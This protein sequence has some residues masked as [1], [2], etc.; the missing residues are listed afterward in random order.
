MAC[1]FSSSEFGSNGQ[2]KEI[3]S[4]SMFPVSY[5]LDR[6]EY[7]LGFLASKLVREEICAAHFV[8]IMTRR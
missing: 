3:G 7:L 6:M 4:R 2:S 1:S 5:I 8:D